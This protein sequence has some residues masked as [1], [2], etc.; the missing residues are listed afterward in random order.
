[1]GEVLVVRAMGHVVRVR[2]RV[3]ERLGLSASMAAS[4]AVVMA[5]VGG[6]GLGLVPRGQW[7]WPKWEE[8][9]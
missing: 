9:G 6:V 2:A 1:M 8:W 7:S 4:R 5:E 3:T